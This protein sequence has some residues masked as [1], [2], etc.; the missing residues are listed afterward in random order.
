ME[1]SHFSC[2]W[3]ILQ[4]L[5]AVDGAAMAEFCNISQ[6]RI[7]SESLVNNNHMVKVDCNINSTI[8][9]LVAYTAVGM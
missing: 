2:P 7:N 1:C 6:S 4:W 8:S 5:V 3:Y 9:K